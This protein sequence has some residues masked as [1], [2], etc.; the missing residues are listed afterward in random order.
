MNKHPRKGAKA[1][2]A[3]GSWVSGAVE[4]SFLSVINFSNDFRYTRWVSIRHRPGGPTTTT[5]KLFFHDEEK[6]TVRRR[7]HDVE[8][9][10]RCISAAKGGAK[11]QHVHG[12]AWFSRTSTRLRLFTPPADT[13]PSALGGGGERDQYFRGNARR[14]VTRRRKEE[15]ERAEKGENR[16]RKRR[17]EKNK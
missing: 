5:I 6:T 1:H 14:R 8:R 13:P 12:L 2:V 15:S 11:V 10:G 4:P 16:D 7:R 9:P 17:G 3:E